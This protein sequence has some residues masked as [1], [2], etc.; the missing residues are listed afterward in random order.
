LVAFKSAHYSTGGDLF[1]PSFASEAAL[2]KI[3]CAVGCGALIGERRRW[4]YPF[5][6]GVIDLAAPQR[7]H[8][9]L[10]AEARLIDLCA[11]WVTVVS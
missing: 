8:S 1:E 9:Q 5:R 6:V 4:R 2:P 7:D 3:F 11:I 10:H